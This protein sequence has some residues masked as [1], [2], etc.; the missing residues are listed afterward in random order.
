MKNKKCMSRFDELLNKQLKNTG[1]E[2]KPIQEILVKAAVAELL[3][4]K[5]LEQREI[6]EFSAVVEIDDGGSCKVNTSSV[7]D[8][9]EPEYG[10]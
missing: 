9:S 5:L 4:E 6:C 7:I 2:L 3:A 8:C 10:V 1:Y